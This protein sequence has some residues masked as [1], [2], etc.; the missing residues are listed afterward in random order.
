MKK[1]LKKIDK[2][3]SKDQKQGLGST[4]TRD[5]VKVAIDKL[6]NGKA[7]GLD[8]IIYELWKELGSRFEDRQEEE[9]PGFDILD[10]LTR[11]FQDIQEH[12]IIYGTGF[13]EGWLC[14]IYKKGDK[15]NIGNYHPITVLN[16]D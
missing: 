2:E 13:A 4:I 3:L 10:T 16:T 8:G 12:G 1:V 15:T 5:K 7:A 9:K 11:V 6:K 14:P